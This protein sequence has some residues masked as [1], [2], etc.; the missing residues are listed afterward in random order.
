MLA[1]TVANAASIYL[2]CPG[3]WHYSD[4]LEAKAD[5]PETLAVTVDIANMTVGIERD[6][7]K[8]DRLS[9]DE[10]RVDDVNQQSS[11]RISLT[12]NRITGVLRYTTWSDEAAPTLLVLRWLLPGTFEGTCK[13]AQKLF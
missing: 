11:L 12:L 2:S 8:I 9:D 7:Y 13:P 10:V 4:A 5:S 3:T 6:V 1:A